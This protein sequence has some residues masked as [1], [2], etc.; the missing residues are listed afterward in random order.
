MREI[1]PHTIAA[2]AYGFLTARLRLRGHS[3]T[4]AH[5]AATSS[6]CVGHSEQLPL[7]GDTFQLAEAAVLELDARSSDKVLHRAGYQHFSWLGAGGNPCACM[8]R[9]SSDLAVY[10]L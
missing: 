9:D 2:A 3:G 10:Q 4:L 1:P 6:A 7:A 8:N 5:T